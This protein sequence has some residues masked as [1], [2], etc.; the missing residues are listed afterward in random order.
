[1]ERFTILVQGKNYELIVGEYYIIDYFDDDISFQGLEAKVEDTF[2]KDDGK[3]FFFIWVPEHN[4]D[5]LVSDVEI[6]SIFL[7]GAENYE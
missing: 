5:Y 1:M 3:T 4:E 7:K 2:W 6:R